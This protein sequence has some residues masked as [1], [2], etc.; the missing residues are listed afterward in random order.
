MAKSKRSLNK[1]AGCGNTWFPKGKDKSFKCPNCGGNSISTEA[2]EA[3]EN[4]TAGIKSI[5][6]IG[7]G[8]LAIY[9]AVVVGGVVANW[10]DKE[11]PPDLGSASLTPAIRPTI[12][13]SLKTEEVISSGKETES[14]PRN[15]LL[16]APSLQAAPQNPTEN[17][18]NETGIFAN[19]NCLWRECEKPMFA[20]FQE[21]NHRKQ[22]PIGHT[23]S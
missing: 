8:V 5:F 17:C 16:K 3:A 13:E 21:C 9:F 23:G 11:K 22:K 7:A 2:E 14:S 10:F 4:F 15:D 6:K 19:N 18:K 20:D 12:A 1:C